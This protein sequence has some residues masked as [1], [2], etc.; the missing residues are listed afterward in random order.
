M[1]RQAQRFVSNGGTRTGEARVSLITLALVLAKLGQH[2]AARRARRSFELVLATNCASWKSFHR[3]DT[4]N[5]VV[6]S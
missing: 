4:D 1:H 3:H 6:I 2:F 5:V